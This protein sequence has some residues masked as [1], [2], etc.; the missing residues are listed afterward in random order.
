MMNKKFGIG[1]LLSSFISAI[2]VSAQTVGATF[3]SDGTTYKITVRNITTHANEVAICEIT[4]N[5]V[6]T[7]PS[8]VRNTADNEDYSVTAT[9]GISTKVSKEITQLILPASLKRIKFQSFYQTKSSGDVKLTSV[10]IPAGCTKIEQMCFVGPVKL[11]SFT[12]E[13]GNKNYKSVEGVIFSKDGKH[14]IVYPAA[15]AGKYTVPEGTKYIDAFAFFAAQKLTAIHIASS[16]ETIGDK[17]FRYANAKKVT[18]APNASLKSIGIHSFAESQ[19]TGSIILPASLQSTAQCAFFM[20]PHLTEIHIANGS[21]LK[22]IAN[23]SFSTNAN[24]KV[25]KFDGSSILE[26]IGDLS[27]RNNPKLTAFEVPASVTAIHTNVFQNTP[28]LECVTFQEKASITKILSKSFANSGIKYIALPASVTTIETL[29]FDNCANLQAVAIPSSLK[30]IDMG[31]FKH[32]EKLTEFQVDAGHTQFS[33]FDGMLCNKDRTTLFLFP[34]GR[35]NAKQTILPPVYKIASYAFY[36]CENLTNL[37]FPATI[38]NIEDKAFTLCPN[39]KSVSFIASSQ[40][41]T[42]TAVQ[43]FQSAQPKDITIYT[44]KAWY[45]NTENNA[46]IIQ[47]YELFKAVH[48]SF[49]VTEGYDCGVEYLPLSATCTGVVGW[50]DKHTSI[51][52]NQSVT[53]EASSDADRFGKT[54]PKVAYETTSMLDHAFEKA[55]HL[56]AIVVLADINYM[57]KRA[58]NAASVR[59]IYLLGDMPVKHGA[60]TSVFAAGQN[61]YVKE[62]KVSAY[63]ELW[64]VETNTLNIT[65]KIPLNREHTIDVVCYPFDV[66]FPADE[67]K[68]SKPWMLAD[69]TKANAPDN[70]SVHAIAITNDYVP[71]F[72]GVLTRV[73]NMGVTDSYCQID[74]TQAHD[75]TVIESLG[76]AATQD[77]RLIGVV[78]DTAVGTETGHRHYVFNA[79]QG[80]FMLAETKSQIPFFTGYLQMKVQTSGATALALTFKGI[81]TG[82]T[83]VLGRNGKSD[84]NAP[85]YNLN[86]LRVSHPSHGIY[87]QNGKKLIIK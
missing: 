48:P 25:F 65:S 36:G 15:K 69:F 83:K 49:I 35:A 66:T 54:F 85:Y 68:G 41:P 64:E 76:Y 28:L 74:E 62:S 40:L 2:T 71:A 31:A 63:K 13:A 39:L 26:T 84:E 86:G 3:T 29:A 61:I 47:Y 44:R 7:I 45:D 22:T 5:G 67:N 27:F 72:V 11:T 52:L 50:N 18:F 37:S 4:G 75:K 55:T 1:L 42:L 43:F 56:K 34:A 33:S 16:V 73:P 24:L 81:E 8:T 79:T 59:D 58:F 6:V 87:I 80:K 51:V 19:L 60:M 77:N 53:E 46:T 38:N 9:D 57:G 23:S 17:A 82:I 32:C 10:T 30:R 14:L 12:V 21:H 70:P 20:I 78:E